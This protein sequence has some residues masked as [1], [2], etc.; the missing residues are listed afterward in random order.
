MEHDGALY[1]IECG[2]IELEWR[3]ST[4]INE[5]WSMDTPEM[6]NH[7]RA[8]NLIDEHIVAG[9]LDEWCKTVFSLIRGSYRVDKLPASQQEK[10]DRETEEIFASAEWKA[11][12]NFLR[13]LRSPDPKQRERFKAFSE[14]SGLDKSLLGFGNG[15]N[16]QTAYPLLA[17]LETAKR[18]AVGRQKL[19]VPWENHNTEMRHILRE[20]HKGRPVAEIARELAE[21][22]GLAQVESRS[23][24]Y[25]KLFAQKR[26]LR[27]INS[28]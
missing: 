9:D 3:V 10:F 21:G 1:L 12:R 5:G 18:A 24:Y 15:Y 22:L 11:F 20:Q 7:L 14:A 2:E 6:R 19:A 25:I 26:S 8:L 16:L 17:P 23:R 28:V 13:G 27:E 4:A